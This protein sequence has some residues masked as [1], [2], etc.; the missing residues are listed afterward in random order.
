MLTAP[1]R[2]N[3]WRDAGHTSGIRRRE[4]ALEEQR[5]ML[6][7]ELAQAAE[8][9]ATCAA[10]AEAQRAEQASSINKHTTIKQISTLH[11]SGVLKTRLG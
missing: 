5:A 2:C 4:V 3:I 6:T 1:I 11:L 10:M 7:R 9:R 8:T